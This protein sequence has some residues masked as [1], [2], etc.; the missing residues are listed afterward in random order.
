MINLTEDELAFLERMDKEKKQH[1]EAQKNYRIR[2]TQNDPEYRE[3]LRE[4]MKNYNEKKKNKYTS[5]KKKQLEEAPPKTVLI[6]SIKDDII[7]NRRTRKGQ[8]EIAEII[9]AYQTRKT[10]LKKNTLYCMSKAI[11]DYLQ[12][13]I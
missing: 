12:V 11:I 8:K 13:R 7:R 9:P 4:Y 5:I 6:P 3:K 2:K 1:A 10:E